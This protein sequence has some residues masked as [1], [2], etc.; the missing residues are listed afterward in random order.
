MVGREYKRSRGWRQKC[1]IHVFF[2]PTNVDKHYCN[3]VLYTDSFLTLRL[4]VEITAILV[5][6][7]RGVTHCLR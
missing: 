7:V 2:V 4:L 1:Y 6:V 3:L 5:Q